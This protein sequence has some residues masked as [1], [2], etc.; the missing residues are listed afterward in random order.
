MIRLSTVKCEFTN[1]ELA[2]RI[3]NGE[4]DLIPTLWEQT[5]ALICPT[6][7]RF[8]SSY[9]I[10]SRGYTS[11]DIEQE[12]FVIF[13][14]MLT[15]YDCNAELKFCSYLKYSAI[16]H[17]NNIVGNRKKAVGLDLLNGALS[18]DEP[19]ADSGEELTLADT[20]ADK[21]NDYEAADDRIFNAELHNSLEKALSELETAQSECI[22]LRYYDD[23]N[24]AETGE[25][26]NIPKEEARRNI[27]KGFGQLR[28]NKELRK[29]REEILSGRAYNHIGYKSFMHNGSIEEM[30]VELFPPVIDLKP[31]LI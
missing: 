19:I 12:C 22:R 14:N 11:A 31:D 16:N 15:A 9:D 3:K 29:F 10:E 30:L 18:L 25:R 1:E 17:L 20:I 26:M 6:V 5:K 8:A 23:L 7:Q 27:N 24:I 28:K 4:A 2:E 21:S 13:S